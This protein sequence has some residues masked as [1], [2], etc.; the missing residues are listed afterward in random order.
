MKLTL[1]HLAP[2]LPYNLNIYYELLNDRNQQAWRLTPTNV[3]FCIENQNKPILR[4][5]SD[6]TKE[7]EVNGEK[8][9]PIVELLKIIYAD[10]L[11]PEE[12][13]YYNEIEYGLTGHARA[14]FKYRAQLEIMIPDFNLLKQPY[15]IVNKLFEWHFDVFNLIENNLAIDINTLNK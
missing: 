14:W 2:Y 10:K 13:S 7:I 8:F 15:F 5:L 1:E 6:L 12:D 3:N 4:P 9:I 11:H